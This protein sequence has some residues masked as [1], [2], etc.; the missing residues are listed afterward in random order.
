MEKRVEGLD[1]AATLSGLELPFRSMEIHP[2]I[3]SSAPATGQ[4]ATLAA[5]HRGSELVGDGRVDLYAGL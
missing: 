4:A 5:E 1:I 2:P 3:L